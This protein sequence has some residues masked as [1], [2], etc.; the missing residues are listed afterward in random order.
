MQCEKRYRICSL[1]CVQIFFFLLSTGTWRQ[2]EKRT[3]FPYP[4]ATSG[5]SSL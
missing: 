3:I 5:S 1:T 4:R 2:C